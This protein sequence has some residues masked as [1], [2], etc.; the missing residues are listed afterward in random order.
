MLPQIEHPA[1]ASGIM[2][3]TEK[4][5]LGLIAAVT[6]SFF[7]VAG[8]MP[9]RIS[10]GN[11]LLGA[12][13]VVLLQSLL[14]DLWLLAKGRRKPPTHP[15]RVGQCMCVESTVGITGVAVGLIL[16]LCRV[17][18]TAPMGRWSWGAFVLVSLGIGFLM[19]DYVIEFKPWR[20][21]RDK[22][23]LNIIVQWDG[24]GRNNTK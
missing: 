24:K 19:K 4:I 14:R 1:E 16:V 23:H 21:R 8:V 5:E 13:S 22:D 11:L 3:V 20:I 15:P 6:V 18:M 7:L 2:S 10:V 12:A 9:E 17:G